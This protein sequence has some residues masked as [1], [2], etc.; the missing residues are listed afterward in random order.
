MATK[1]PTSYGML[2]DSDTATYGMLLEY[3]MFHTWE[4]KIHGNQSPPTR[5]SLEEQTFFGI[6]CPGCFIS[7]FLSVF[8]GGHSDHSYSSHKNI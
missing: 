6:S 1:P 7:L 8:C 4:N 5:S 3:H 2:L